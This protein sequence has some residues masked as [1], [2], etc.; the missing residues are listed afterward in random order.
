MTRTAINS[1]NLSVETTSNQLHFEL[2]LSQNVVST[3]MFPSQQTNC[4]YVTTSEREHAGA[5]IAQNMNLFVGA[6]SLQGHK[7]ASQN[8]E[9]TP[10]EGVS[11]MTQSRVPC[12]NLL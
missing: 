9:V 10:Q 6:N 12:M 4:S 1:A 8:S 11:S 2:I 7:Y 5:S 3:G